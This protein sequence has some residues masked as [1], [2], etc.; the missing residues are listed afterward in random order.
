MAIISVVKITKPEDKMLSFF[1]TAHEN[2]LFYAKNI[3]I[4]ELGRLAKTDE[5]RTNFKG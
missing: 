3:G 5:N 1:P 4:H 2:M